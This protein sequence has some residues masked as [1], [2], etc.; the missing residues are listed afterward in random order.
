MKTT[1]R[2]TTRLALQP[3]ARSPTVR[4]EDP[5][6]SRRHSDR[7][8]LR[9]LAGLL[10][11]LI[12]VGCSQL[13]VGVTW[14]GNWDTSVTLA[15]DSTPVF[16]GFSSSLWL[17]IGLGALTLESTS[18]FSESGFTSQGFAAELR[19][20]LLKKVHL[21]VQFRP[22]PPQFTSFTSDMRVV[23]PDS[24]T[25]IPLE[26]ELKWLY[27]Y[28]KWELETELSADL[29]AC[30]VRID[31]YYKSSDACSLVYESTH[32]DLSGLTF[33]CLELDAYLKISGDD[34]F[35]SLEVS[36][37]Y[38]PDDSLLS[39][40]ADV[41]LD[42]DD[43]YIEVSP[44]LNV[45][46]DYVTLEL[47]VD[48]AAGTG[49]VIHG[50]RIESLHAN[51]RLQSTTLRLSHSLESGKTSLSLHTPAVSCSATFKHLGGLF[52]LH[53]VRIEAGTILAEVVSIDVSFTWGVTTGTE[54]SASV[55]VS[56]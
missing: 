16:E 6:G 4:S 53:D 45:W 9:I 51:C 8:P 17:G 7:R 43:L 47:D 15:P 25:G 2:P 39:W 24:W 36:A 38:S 26:I 20:D 3:G 34:G 44:S 1:T 37:S 14:S 11:A 28:G 35:E 56:F 42:V 41:E 22:V 18:Q 49:P 46:A 52:S 5:H 30:H 55:D 23:L 29:A 33:G 12:A 31:T 54:L 32:I 27:H 13:A 10:Y 48:T 50:L 19:T 40:S 21:S